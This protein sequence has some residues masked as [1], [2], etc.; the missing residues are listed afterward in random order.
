MT[1]LTEEKQRLRDIVVLPFSRPELFS[2]GPAPLDL[3]AILLGP[4]IVAIRPWGG[5]IQDSDPPRSNPR[6]RSRFTKWVALQSVSC[7]PDTLCGFARPTFS[8]PELFSRGFA[9]L[10]LSKFTWTEN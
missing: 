4:T 7:F 8:R 6:T 3:E 10:E 5:P 1:G 9:P 2:R